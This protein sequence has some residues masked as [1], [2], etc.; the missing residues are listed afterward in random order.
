ML[1][2]Q[3]T[4]ADEVVFEGVGIHSGTHS[5]LRLKPA[6]PN[7]GRVFHVVQGDQRAETT[8]FALDD[9]ALVEGCRRIRSALPTVVD[10]P[11]S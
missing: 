7:T 9:E 2:Q 3:R 4:L 5:V 1:R 10:Q 11:S 8:A 6:E